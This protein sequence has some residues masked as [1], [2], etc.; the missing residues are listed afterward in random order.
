[1]NREVARGDF[2]A[3]ENGNCGV[4]NGV[5]FT[6]SMD[7]EGFSKAGFLQKT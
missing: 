6:H 5:S 2:V 1:M 7:L 4:P 3:G